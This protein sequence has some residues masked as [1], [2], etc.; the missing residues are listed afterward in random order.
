MAQQVKNLPAIR[1][2]LVSYLGGEDPLE[3]KIA[4]QYSCLKDSV[5]GGSWR[6]TVHGIRQLSS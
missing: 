3:K 2:M 5:D 1:E 6:A 4:I